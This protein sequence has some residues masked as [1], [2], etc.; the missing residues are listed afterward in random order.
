MSIILT[1]SPYV[2]EEGGGRKDGKRISTLR[3]KKKQYPKPPLES[4]EPLPV[5]SSYTENN[6]ISDNY[7]SFQKMTDS[8]FPSLSTIS[9]SSGGMNVLDGSNKEKND[10]FTKP[11]IQAT[12]FYKN[13]PTQQ[14]KLDSAL[15]KLF[16]KKKESDDLLEGMSNFNNKEDDNSLLTNDI[17]NPI[18]NNNV[19]NT[20]V[21]QAEANHQIPT[22]PLHSIPTDYLH[23]SYDHS[24]TNYDKGYS[25][26]VIPPELSA[27]S[28][29]GTVPSSL[30]QQTVPSETTV[31]FDDSNALLLEKINY[32]IYL[33]EQQKP[34]KS[35]HTTE[36]FVLYSFFGVFMIYIVDSFARSGRYIR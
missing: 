21:V 25:S 4:Q 12:S 18:Q 6:S 10:P 24:Y 2:S 16:G 34:Q 27:Y 8:Y 30:K 15:N 13:T 11:E 31:V 36:E 28:Y 20:N 22:K 7:S 17:S 3:S 29:P 32:M 9:E 19:Y 5:Y 26:Y 35:K 1:A 14:S 23:S 33:L